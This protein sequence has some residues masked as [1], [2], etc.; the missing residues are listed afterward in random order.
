MVYRGYQKRQGNSNCEVGKDMKVEIERMTNRKMNLFI[1]EE[2]Q[3][4]GGP[5][6]KYNAI[7]VKKLAIPCHSVPWKG[8]SIA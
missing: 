8:I 4:E 3:E 2:A 7:I 6:L 1:L 5:F